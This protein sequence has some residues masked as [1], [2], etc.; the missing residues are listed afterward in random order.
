[1]ATPT[2]IAAAR[3]SDRLTLAIDEIARQGLRPHCTDQEVSHL[4]LSEYAAERALAIKLCRGC[5]IFNVCGEV[6]SARREPFGVWGGR[7]R[8]RVPGKVGRPPKRA[9]IDP[10]E[11]A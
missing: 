3:A 5:P 4:W 8:T 1:M 7:D 11:A 2:K 10:D 6:A 9:V